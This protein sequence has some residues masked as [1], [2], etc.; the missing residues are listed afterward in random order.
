MLP[1]IAI[2]HVRHAQVRQSGA[3]LGT[4]AGT[5][6][7][8]VGLGGSVNVDLQPAALV[9]LGIWWWSIGKTWAETAVLARPS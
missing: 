8:T 1:A 5:A 3:I 2:L 9:V 7:V 6:M 4:I